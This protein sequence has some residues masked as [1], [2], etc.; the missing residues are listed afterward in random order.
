MQSHNFCEGLRFFS[1]KSRFFSEKPSFS[2]LCS[3]P[4]EKVSGLWPVQLSAN[5][6]SDDELNCEI[7][8]GNVF[9]NLCV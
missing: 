8:K 9:I 4:L 5:L 7:I 1:E 6:C 3:R 2:S